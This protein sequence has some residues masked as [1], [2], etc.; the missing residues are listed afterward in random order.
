MQ[1]L[2]F[3]IC[4]LKLL[5]LTFGILEIVPDNLPI[6]GNL[7]EILAVLLAQK[8]G[9]EVKQ[10]L[11]DVWNKGRNKPYGKDRQ[12]DPTDYINIQAKVVDNQE[13]KTKY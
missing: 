1:S 5:N 4:V 9:V 12:I 11:V 2:I 13:A 6:V 8:S 7:D 3:I 10:V